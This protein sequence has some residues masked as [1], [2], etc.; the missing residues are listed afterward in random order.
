[1]MNTPYLNQFIEKN[2]PHASED[3]KRSMA[4]LIITNLMLIFLTGTWIPIILLLEMPEM[5]WVNTSGFIGNILLFSSIVFF[6]INYKSARFILL[7]LGAVLIG[8]SSLFYGIESNTYLHLVFLPI[9]MILL[10]SRKEKKAF[11]AYLSA[12]IL[13]Y[14]V[15]VYSNIYYGALYQVPAD[16][17]FIYNTIMAI[18]SLFVALYFAYFFYSENATYKT[19][20][21]NEREKSDQLLLSIFP[22]PIANRLRQSKE[23]VADSFDNITILFADIV[24]F[25]EYSS[26]MSP[27]ALVGMLDE[28]FSEFDGLLDKYN[29]EKIKTIGDAYMAV[30]GLPKPD[31]NHCHNVTNLALEINEVIKV[32]FAKKYNL[33]LRIGINTGKAV[34]GVIGEKKFSY[35]LWG[36]S[37]NIASRF[38][39][40]GQPGR[41]HLTEAVKHKLGDAYEFD[42]AG[43]IDIK[44]KGKMKSYFLK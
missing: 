10:F 43:E 35:D 14:I 39:T 25:T 11:L 4:T 32:K 5:L 22:E 42:Y 3:R 24:G 38:E 27:T 37:V 28:V 41:I 36:D 44:G 16:T 2:Y 15:I 6:S 30:G 19:L 18:D 20:L 33:K 40:S 13:M 8:T 7:F 1:M 21:A 29:V 31:I 9:V 12:V 26:R 17:F 23:S 34:A